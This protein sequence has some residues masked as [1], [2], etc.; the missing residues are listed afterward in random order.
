MNLELMF[1]KF[2]RVFDPDQIIFCEYEPGNDFYMILNGQVRI[3][4]TVGSSI[5][6]MDLINS[7]DIFGEMSLLDGQPRSA[8]AVAVSEVRTL[9]FNRENF[10]YL[11][12]K[13]PQIAFKLLTLF[14]TRIYDQKRRLQILLFDDITG[15]VADVLLMLSEK[16]MVPEN[17]K[18]VVL[19]AS[20][21]D[22]ASW[23]GQPL[24]EVQKAIQ[25]LSKGGKIEFQ[26]DKVVIH[27]MQDIIRTVLQK[28]KEIK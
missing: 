11:M 8:T 17:A 25:I 6:T 15:K 4:K 27:N 21:E 10:D 24:T 14:S 20:Q 26:P 13:T 28:R 19:K 22:I 12:N 2:G 23:C 9:N 1:D 5:K 7:G 18:N 3:L 16:Q